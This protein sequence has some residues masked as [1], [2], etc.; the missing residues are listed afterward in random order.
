MQILPKTHSEKQK[1][2]SILL[3]AI[4]SRILL[5]ILGYIQLK[6]TGGENHSFFYWL[7]YGWESADSEHYLYLAQHG[8]QALGEKQNLIV[9]YPL[10]PLFIRLFSYLCLGSFK[11][12]ALL[13]SYVSFILACV[14][15]YKLV[16]LEAG[17][18]CALR[19]VLFFVLFPFSF[20]FHTAMTE[21]L[22]AL[23]SILTLYKMRKKQFFSA[24]L[25]GFLSALC[26]T[27]GILLFAPVL[28]EIL[29][30]QKEE[31]WKK[32]GKSFLLR[33]F[34]SLLIPMGFFLYLLLN[35]SLFG[36]FFAYLSYQ[37]AAPW[38]QSATFFWKSLET[39]F[40][41][42][43]AFDNYLD[44]CIYVPQILLFFLSL[45]LC[46]VGLKK[47][48]RTSFV[49]YAFL[50]LLVTYSAS[51]LL[52]GGRYLACNIPLFII[53]ALCIQNKRGQG[54][55]LLSSAMFLSVYTI[56]FVANYPIM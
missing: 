34:S 19:A 56:L 1:I 46:F 10:Y 48:V 27:Q 28:Y 22:F 23:L 11:A 31:G 38:Y 2:L 17:E 49:G 45:G 7:Y 35:F 29:V 55:I 54:F 15:L 41:N 24:G 4:F 47:G 33:L 50:Y 36:D 32:T 12:S 30:L 21:S 53:S 16:C 44:V 20:F 18:K 26:R 8:Y 40:S 37:S 51:W 25:F 39:Q 52:S 9:F 42:I 14:Y 43:I 6:F 3:L 13:V 5:L